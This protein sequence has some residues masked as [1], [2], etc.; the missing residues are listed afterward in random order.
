M[1]ISILIVL[2]IQF[3]Q[4]SRVLPSVPKK[5]WKHIAQELPIADNLAV[6][7]IAQLSS[8]I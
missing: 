3:F 6:T 7:M 2:H 4:F 1:H 8:Q 5:Y